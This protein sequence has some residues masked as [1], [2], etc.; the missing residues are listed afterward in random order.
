M[1]IQYDVFLENI[2]FNFLTIKS[3]ATFSL[4]ICPSANKYFLM[5]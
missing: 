4:V 1:M 2:K 5:T 3:K